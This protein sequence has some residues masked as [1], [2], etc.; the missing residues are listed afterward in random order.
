MGIPTIRPDPQPTGIL[1]GLHRYDRACRA[2]AF[3]E[4]EALPDLHRHHRLYHDQTPSGTVT[5]PVLSGRRAVDT[6][7]GA[8]DTDVVR[9][10]QKVQ[11]TSY[12]F[13]QFRHGSMVQRPGSLRV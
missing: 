1:L 7:Y 12:R 8:S 2:H 10:Q 9:R 11:C 13:Q 3:V 4:A 5:W 6:G